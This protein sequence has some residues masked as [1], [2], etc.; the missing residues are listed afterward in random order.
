MILVTGAAGLLGRAVV[1]NFN[2]AK[3]LIRA[4]DYSTIPSELADQGIE[5]HQTDLRDI[6]F[7]L[8]LVEGVESIVHLAAW[9]TPHATTPASVWSD[10]VQITSNLVA[11]SQQQRVRKIIYASSQS[12]LGLAWAQLVI[13]PDSLPVDEEHACRPT[14][15]YSMSKLAGERLMQFLAQV[16]PIEIAALRFPVIW[17]HRN[18]TENIASRINTPKQGAKS[19]WAYVDTRDAARAVALA[20]EGDWNGYQCV[21]IASQHAFLP[22]SD[23]QSAVREWYPGLD[24]SGS[25]L[26]TDEAIFSS[27]KAKQL[28]GFESRY[29]WR[30]DGIF[31]ID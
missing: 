28:F 26:G 7:V 12:V 11:A 31:E 18:F 22:D 3:S 5:Y 25:D 20:I 9:P 15:L 17:E 30:R 21:N 24:W 29:S 8:Q 1:A 14:D 27:K 10:N 16:A 4:V 23:I 13:A 19:Q 2:N 6:N